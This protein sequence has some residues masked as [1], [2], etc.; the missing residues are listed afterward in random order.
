MIQSKLK[1]YEAVLLLLVLTVI[2]VYGCGAAAQY[3][4]ET[5]TEGKEIGRW[6][7]SI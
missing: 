5:E 7:R 6:K 2:G 1:K 3:M 4:E